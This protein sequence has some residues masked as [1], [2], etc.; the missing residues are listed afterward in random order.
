MLYILLN[1]ST[2]PFNMLNKYFWSLSYLNVK[3]IF[4]IFMIL[5]FFEIIL[6]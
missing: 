6:G 1:V 5:Y 2:T 4:L 3:V